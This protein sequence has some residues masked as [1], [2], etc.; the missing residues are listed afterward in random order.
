MAWW[1]KLK[2]DNSEKEEEL[3]KG[4]ES[5]GGLEKGDLPAMIIS[6]LLVIVPVVVLVLVVLALIIYLPVLLG[7]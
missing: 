4:I 7:H 1:K 5:E 2:K 3:K 6:A